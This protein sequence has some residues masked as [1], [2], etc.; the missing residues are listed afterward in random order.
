MHLISLPSKEL[1]TKIE[2]KILV[3]YVQR[4]YKISRR[5]EQE[6]KQK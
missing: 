3:G 1:T 6:G 4:H 5:A 2:K